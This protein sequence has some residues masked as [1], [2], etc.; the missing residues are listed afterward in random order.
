MPVVPTRPIIVAVR[1]DLDCIPCFFAQAVRAARVAGLDEAVTRQLLADLGRRLPEVDPDLP[2]PASAPLLYRRLAELAGVDDPFAAAKR[3]HTELA[4]GLL[5]RLRRHVESSP[6][7][8]DAALRVAA[9]GNI[10]DLGAME[11]VGDLE[12]VLERALTADHS[13][14]DLASLAGRLRTAT[15]VL[16]VGD[17]AGEAVFDRVLLETWRRLRPSSELHFSVRGSAV[18]NDV[19]EA[20]AR[21]A[22]VDRVARLVST[23]SDLPGVVLERAGAAFRRVFAD[24]DLVVAKGQGNYETLDDAGREVFFLLTVKCRVVAARLD[25][26]LGESV[27]IRG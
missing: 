21:A 9:A 20:D 1:A 27:L 11:E 18:I 6:D 2:P 19:T 23:G 3:R 7:P 13:R 12:A 16:L 14:W 24:A 25:L 4:L 15:S 22:G 26:P 10:L 17:N 8:L 5:G